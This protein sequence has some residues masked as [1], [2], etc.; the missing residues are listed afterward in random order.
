MKTIHANS[1]III[2]IQECVL[3]SPGVMEL[4]ARFSVGGHAISI[5]NIQCLTS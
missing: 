4:V 2:I 1:I 5:E 3:N